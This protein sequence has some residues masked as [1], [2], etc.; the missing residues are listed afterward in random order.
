MKTGSQSI[1]DDAGD[2]FKFY[3]T[4][5]GDKKGAG[6]IGNQGGK[7][8]YFGMLI[9]A[10][11]YRYQIATITDKNNNP[12]SFIVNANGSIQHSYKTQYKED[13]DVLIET[14]VSGTTKFETTKGAYENEITGEYFVKSDLPGVKIDDH[15][16]TVDVIK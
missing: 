2:T 11:D 10:D 4:T 14:Y 16:N 15:V 12:H 5:K 9:Q 13:G 6:I 7:L 3:F 8:Y 1:R